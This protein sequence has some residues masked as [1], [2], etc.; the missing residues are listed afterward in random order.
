[1][2]VGM[3]WRQR[4]ARYLKDDSVIE[5]MNRVPN[6]KPMFMGTFPPRLECC[7]NQGVPGLLEAGW[8][9]A[10][11][12][13]FLLWTQLLSPWEVGSLTGEWGS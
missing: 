3:C 9:G 8:S 7:E 6:E 13:L 12:F 10:S 5:S 4:P 11:V 1:M 2:M